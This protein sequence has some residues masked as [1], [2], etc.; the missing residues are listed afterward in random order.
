MLVVLTRIQFTQNVA[1]D[2]TAVCIAELKKPQNF[3]R[4]ILPYAVG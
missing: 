1:Y 4:A 2:C 3:E